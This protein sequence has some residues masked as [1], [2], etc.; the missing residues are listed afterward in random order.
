VLDR[1][2]DH[3]HGRVE[4][5][6]LEGRHRQHFAFPHAA[7]VVQVTRKT[8]GLGT[9]RWRTATVYAL[10]SLTFAQAGPARPADLLR[11]HWAIENGLHHVRDT[12]FAED[13]SP[14]AH[15]RPAGHGL[16]AQPRDR[17]A[18]PGRPRNHPLMK[19]TLRENA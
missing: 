4:P 19:R 13:A 3:A 18:Q 14:A 1:T 15:W 2:R 7:Q 8:R 17:R 16:P 6:T 9:R 12:T 5:R 11:G 10:T